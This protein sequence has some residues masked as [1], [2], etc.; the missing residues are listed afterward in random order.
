MKNGFRPADSSHARTI[1]H[2][3]KGGM[4]Q[5]GALRRKIGGKRGGIYALCG[6]PLTWA[7][8]TSRSDGLEASLCDWSY[9]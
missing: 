2:F 7:R 9:S 4:S 3:G 6:G 1:G 5:G 8:H